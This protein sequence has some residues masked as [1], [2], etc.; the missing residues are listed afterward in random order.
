MNE[1]YDEYLTLPE[2]IYQIIRECGS[3][4]DVRHNTRLIA[5]AIVSY[6]YST[7]FLKLTNPILHC[8]IPIL[9]SEQLSDVI[10]NLEDAIL[11]YKTIY[12]TLDDDAPI[13][14][15]I[16]HIYSDFGISTK[17]VQNPGNMYLSD[18]IPT[19]R[20]RKMYKVLN[21]KLQ[22][23]MTKLKINN[24]V[25]YEF[26]DAYDCISIYTVKHLNPNNKYEE[27]GKVSKDISIH[28]IFVELPEM[29]LSLTDRVI[30]NITPII[31]NKRDIHHC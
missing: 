26:S 25:K 1:P 22:P 21:K 15:L 6:R 17:K 13:Y 2:F 18:L 7:R 28:I 4:H 27:R 23:L 8:E 30:E 29:A 14:P 3:G 12:S 11:S 10:K 24:I 20:I 16:K 19:N 5:L 9:N 31:N